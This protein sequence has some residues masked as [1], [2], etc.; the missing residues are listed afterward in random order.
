MDDL[1]SFQTI[2]KVSGRSKKCT[3]HLENVAGLS[4]ILQ[5][6]LVCAYVAELKIDAIYALYPESFCD[7]NLAIRKVFAFCDYAVQEPLLA[8]GLRIAL[9]FNLSAISIKLSHRSRNFK[10]VQGK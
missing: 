10:V 4:K 9:F 1:E 3:D 8:A 2:W 6:H 7:K 5:N